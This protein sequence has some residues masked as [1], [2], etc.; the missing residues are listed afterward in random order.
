VPDARSKVVVVPTVNVNG[1]EIYYYDDDFTDPWRASEVVLINHYGV[2]DSTLYRRW[3]PILARN[4]RVIRWDRPGHGRSQVP[5]LGYKLTVDDIVSMFTGFLDAI[6]VQQVH[7]VGDKVSCPAG[8][9][10][11]VRHPERVKTLTLAAAFLHVQRMRDNFIRQANQVLEEGSWVNA[12]SAYARRD[13]DHESFEQRMR[14]LYYQEVWA[15][16]PAHVTSA[17]FSLVQDPAFDVTP[18][19]SQVKAPTLLLSPDNGGTLV[20]MEE[21]A[22]IRDTIPDCTQVVFPG[23]TSL[24]PYQEAEW[25]AEQTLAFLRAHKDE[26]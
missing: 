21:Q 17:A 26:A 6:G 12:F 1:Y 5:P 9:A 2:G 8:I 13:H 15:R 11:A 3:V 7:Y 10:L 18:L 23:G 19:L 4:Y 16:T 24:L 22:L 20:T 14:D 25:C